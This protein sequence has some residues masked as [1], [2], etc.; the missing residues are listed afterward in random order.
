M[1]RKV[2]ICII[3]TSYVHMRVHAFYCCVLSYDKIGSVDDKIASPLYGTVSRKI[4]LVIH[5]QIFQD[6]Q[7]KS[8]AC[9]EMYGLIINSVPNNFM[10]DSPILDA[11]G[12]FDRSSMEFTKI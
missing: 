1:S 10:M 9:I 7:K 5:F 6:K 4:T 2:Y 12:P 8:N 11:Y 3:L